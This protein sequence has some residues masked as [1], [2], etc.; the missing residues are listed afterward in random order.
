MATA[1]SLVVIL[2]LTVKDGMKDAVFVNPNKWIFDPG[3]I[4]DMCVS[5][6]NI[7][8]RCI[9]YVEGLFQFFAVTSRAMIPVG[10]PLVLPIP[11]T[12]PFERMTGAK[13]VSIL[14]L[15]F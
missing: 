15:S 7:S 9:L 3:V 13:F 10:S 4:Q 5:G 8:S 11:I 12:L 1:K 6:N 2:N 14:I